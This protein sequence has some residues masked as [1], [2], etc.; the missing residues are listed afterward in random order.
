MTAKTKSNKPKNFII[1]VCYYQK[2]LDDALLALNKMFKTFDDETIIVIVKNNTEIDTSNIQQTCFT[3]HVI[4]GSNTS[5]EFSAWDEG[6]DYLKKKY[7]LN[8]SLMVFVND[9]FC[10]HRVFTSIDMK[11]FKQG[12]S[13]AKSNENLIAGEFNTTAKQ[14]TILEQPLNGWLSSYLFAIKGNALSKILPLTKSQ[15]MYKDIPLIDF[16]QR[17]INLSN[18]SDNFS[19]H[20]EQ[21]LFP[22]KPSSG[23]YKSGSSSTNQ[24]LMKNKL[25][26]ILN[27]K[28]LAYTAQ[29]NGLI[30]YD[31]YKPFWANLYLKIRY[32]LYKIFY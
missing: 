1:L 15:V 27:E 12:F 23:W 3:H 21:W 20:I 6:I 28:L 10:K 17:T 11:L 22:K 30:L 5:W 19:A 26:A 9:T 16:E 24:D 29:K 25:L 8:D 14:F 2:Y 18:C 7:C 32:E 4:E 31:V 13:Q